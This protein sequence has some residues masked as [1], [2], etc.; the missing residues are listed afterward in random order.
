MES[1]CP[2]YPE[3]TS[4]PAFQNKPTKASIM[5]NNIDELIQGYSDW[6]F[7]ECWNGRLPY[8]INIMFHP[9]NGASPELIIAQMQDAIY[10]C[11]YPT[12]CKR[13]AQHPCRSSQ[14]HL[15]PRCVL[16]FD[17]PV[18]KRK[19]DKPIGRT[20]NLN[21]GFH[22]N[23]FIL[24]PT[25]S[26]LREDFASHINERQDLYVDHIVNGRSLYDRGGI[27]RVHVEPIDFNR[28]RVSDYSLKTV[29]AGKVDY[30]TTI[31]LPRTRKEMRPDIRFIDARA[32]AI[33]DIQASTNVSDEGAMQIYNDPC[34]NRI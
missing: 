31:I 16:F 10:D 26:R 2:I 11:F 20:V 15:L 27:E 22:L 24:I 3:T 29:K 1:Y 6:I 5:S 23:G 8:Y 14:E 21:G 4:T 30:D 19:L 9:L 7:Q 28:Y 32:R 17:L 34:R 12:L 33:K 13:F 25:N 18:W